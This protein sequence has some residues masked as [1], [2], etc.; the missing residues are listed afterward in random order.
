VAPVERS[1]PLDRCREFHRR[2]GQRRDGHWGT[3]AGCA[4]DLGHGWKISPSVTIQ[5]GDGFLLADV[6]GPGAIQSMWISGTCAVKQGRLT[7]LRV[8]W[9]GQDYPSVECPLGDFFASGWGGYAQIS[10]LP[11]TVNPGRGFNSYWPMPF[12]KHCR[13][14]LQNLSDEAVSA[15]YQINCALTDVPDDAARFHAQFRR[16]N[17]LPYKFVYSI[18]DGIQGAGQYVRTYLAVG[19]TNCRWWGEGEIKFYCPLPPTA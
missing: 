5:P 11:V 17:P 2:E 10:S 8:Y 3:G 1:L 7:I 4:R 9:D 6:H 19:V 15:Y 13:I 18:V 12:R 16:V 14:T